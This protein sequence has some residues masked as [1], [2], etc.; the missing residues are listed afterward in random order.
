MNIRPGARGS[1]RA[2]HDV[3]ITTVPSQAIRDMPDRTFATCQTTPCPAD[4]PTHRAPSHRDSPVHP[5]ADLPRHDRPSRQTKP[6]PRRADKPTRAQRDPNLTAP[7]VQALPGQPDTPG[8]FVPNHAT[9]RTGSAR[10][11]PTCLS[12]L[13]PSRSDTPDRAVPTNQASPHP[14]GSCRLTPPYHDDNPSPTTPGRLSTP[15]RRWPPRST[16][17]HLTGPSPS[18]A[19]SPVL[20]APSHDD[21][22]PRTE[23]TQAVAPGRTW[24][25]HAEP[26]RRAVPALTT[27]TCL[28]YPDPPRLT[29]SPHSS[30]HRHATQ[31]PPAQRD[32]PP[33]AGPTCLTDPS[34]ADVPIQSEP[35]RRA[36][37]SRVDMPFPTRPTCRARPGRHSRP[38]LAQPGRHA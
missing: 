25:T 37:P 13:A 35:S 33:P 30:P 22:P 31:I 24:P 10:T 1:P 5:S 9:L 28:T 17:T 12:A 3:P 15:V 34:R 11:T 23:P 38:L 2:G 20:S 6:G 29:R 21:M 18:R 19:D 14:S 7:T 8:R 16:P 27:P 36:Y 26:P 4:M 32:A